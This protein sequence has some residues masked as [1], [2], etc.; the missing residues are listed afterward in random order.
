MAEYWHSISILHLCVILHMCPSKVE[1]TSGKATREGS[2]V[3]KAWSQEPFPL[4]I[5]IMN[6]PEVETVISVKRST[7]LE[8]VLHATT[9][10][11][12]YL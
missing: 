11:K 2:C 1:Q 7:I 12:M 5:L 4:S 8:M 3:K 6:L 9:I 10:F